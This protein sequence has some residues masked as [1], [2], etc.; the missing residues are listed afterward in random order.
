M[1][2]DSLQFK[3]NSTPKTIH[4]PS[5]EKTENEDLELQS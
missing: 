2:N 4:F 3:K 5:V 1:I